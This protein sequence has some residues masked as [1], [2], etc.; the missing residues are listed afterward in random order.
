MLLWGRSVRITCDFSRRGLKL[1]VG[2]ADPSRETAVTFAR[3]CLC[4]VE[5]AITFAGENRAV[6]VRLLVAVVTVVSTVAVQ[7]CAVVMGVSY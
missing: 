4:G 6:L 5:T 7:G 3:S 2:V 1:R